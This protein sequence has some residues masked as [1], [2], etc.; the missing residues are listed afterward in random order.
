MARTPNGDIL[1]PSL[2]SHSHPNPSHRQ[3][4]APSFPNL[5]VEAR[6]WLFISTPTT[7]VGNGAASHHFHID[8]CPQGLVI[9]E[10]GRRGL[11][12]TNG[13]NAKSTHHHHGAF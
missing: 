1:R 7:C 11:A 8:R 12:V 4:G 13:R 2:C 10:Q 9:A 3:F 6:I 5:I